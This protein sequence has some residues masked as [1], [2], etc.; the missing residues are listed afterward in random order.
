MDCTSDS[1]QLSKS[2]NPFTLGERKVSIMKKITIE[3]DKPLTQFTDKEL[4]ALEWSTVAD[5]EYTSATERELLYCSAMT[6]CIKKSYLG[7]RSDD[8][9][10]EVL[11]RVIKN[12]TITGSSYIGTLHNVLTDL[13][14]LSFYDRHLDEV[15]E[16][17]RFYGSGHFKDFDSTKWMMVQQGIMPI[18]KTPILFSYMC[19]GSDYP[20]IRVEK[21]EW[22]D[23]YKNTNYLYHASTEE[24]LMSDMNPIMMTTKEME[25]IGFPTIPEVNR[26]RFY[27]HFKRYWEYDEFEKY[28]SR[29]VKPSYCWDEILDEFYSGNIDSDEF[30]EFWM[31]AWSISDVEE[32]S[33]KTANALRIDGISTLYSEKK[34]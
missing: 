8:F 30:V 23:I 4:L 18:N 5:H 25:S 9:Y 17:F 15:L 6:L 21:S 29:V 31:Y 22:M 2:T 3:I 12:I 27:D 28:A 16:L 34:K 33:K 20:S 24:R 19:S 32:I 7:V 13:I 26:E 10:F 1:V 11:R 14:P